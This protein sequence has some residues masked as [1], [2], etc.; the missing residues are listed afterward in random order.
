M[1]Y[2]A[3]SLDA[4]PQVLL[5]PNTLS[6]DG[7]VALAGVAVSD[8]GSKMAYALADAGCDWITWHVRDVATDKDTDDVIRWS[9][10][11][12][13]SWTKDG[14]GFFYGRYPE[15][16]GRRGPAGLELLPEAVLPQAR[17]AASRTTS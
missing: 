6:E 5:D 2:T 16:Q 3:P 14:E 8:D 10:F 9:K 12:G 13:A 7:T 1:L 17:H 11:S 15:P 4:E